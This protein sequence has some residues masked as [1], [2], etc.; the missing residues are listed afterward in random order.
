MRFPSKEIVERVRRQY[1]IGCRV[2]LVK[3]DDLQAPPIGT[4]GTVMGVDD[5]ASIMVA[6]DNGSGLNVTYTGNMLFQKEFISDPINKKRKQNRGELPQYWVEDTH[7]AI[8]D[9]ETFQYIQDEMERRKQLGAL[10]NKSLNISCFTG[11]IKC[12]YCGV[13]YVHNTRKPRTSNAKRLEFWVCGSRKKKGGH[14]EVGASINQD[15]MKKVLA[16]VLEIDEFDDDVFLE[17]VKHIIGE[18]IF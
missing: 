17:E 15:N 16:E 14:C 6:W 8:I 12:P 7:E 9:L 11:K 3:M 5:T 13:S 1:P 10:A 4:K 18:L 2:E